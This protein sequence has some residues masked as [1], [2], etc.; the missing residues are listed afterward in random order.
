MTRLASNSQGC[1]GT[2]QIGKLPRHQTGFALSMTLVVA[3][4]TGGI[5]TRAA[6]QTYA[7]SYENMPAIPPIGIRI[8]KYMDVPESAKGPAIDPAKG[9]RIQNLGKD[10][11]MVTD[12]ANQAM[13]LVY[14]EGVVM[15]D[16][17]QTLVSAIP[18]AIAEV[19]NKPITHRAPAR[20]YPHHWLRSA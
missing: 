6:A 7:P 20:R 8:G 16:A 14:Q 18:K 5:A 17:P 3:F 13:F 12:N 4:S 1:A 15:V 2:C 19:T 9:Y 11:Y 10:L